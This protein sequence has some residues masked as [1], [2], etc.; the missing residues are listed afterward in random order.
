MILLHRY[1][2]DRSLLF[3]LGMKVNEATSATI[4]WPDLRGHGLN[5]LVNWTSFGGRESDDVLAA[6]DFLRSIKGDGGSQ[7]IGKSIGLYGVEIGAYAA[8]RAAVKDESVAP[9]VLDSIPRSRNELVE[10]TV[11]GYV[12]VNVKP[13]LTAARLATQSYLLDYENQDS[14]QLAAAL[15]NRR[16]LLLAG[17]DDGYLRESTKSLATCFANKSNLETKTDLRLTGFTLPSA[18]GQ[19]GESYDRPVIDF[20][21]KNLH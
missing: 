4:L 3:N 12:G 8:L 7:L 10:G 9:L 2:G 11:R 18:T 5:P 13:L 1:G 17:E 6:L 14:C 19:Q 15:G 20:F 16:V 21:V